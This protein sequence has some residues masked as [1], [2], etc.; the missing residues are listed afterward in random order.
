[1]SAEQSES[2]EEPEESW[3]SRGE[4][5]ERDYQIWRRRYDDAQRRIEERCRQAEE[6]WK[7]AHP[8]LAPGW[9]VTVPVRHLALPDLP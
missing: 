1:M 2:G 3:L 8:W 5:V 9:C 6:R 4:I 7:A